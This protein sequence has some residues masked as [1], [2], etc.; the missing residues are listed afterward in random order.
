MTVK[1]YEYQSGHQ[2]VVYYR[3]D[4]NDSGYGA[5]AQVAYWFGPWGE[6]PDEPSASW[7]VCHGSPAID[8]FD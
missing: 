2:C 5:D 8:E 3:D 6:E 4:D 1:Y 7:W